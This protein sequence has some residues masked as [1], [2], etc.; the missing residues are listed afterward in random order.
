MAGREGL[1]DVDFDDVLPKVKLISRC[2][3]RW[4]YDN[5]YLDG[6]YAEAAK[7]QSKE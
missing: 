2:R 7:M 6:A 5:S 4:S 3:G 1:W